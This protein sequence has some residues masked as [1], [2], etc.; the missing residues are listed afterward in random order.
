[1][2]SHHFISAGELLLA[3][4]SDENAEMEAAMVEATCV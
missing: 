2:Q 1:V 3:R 4:K